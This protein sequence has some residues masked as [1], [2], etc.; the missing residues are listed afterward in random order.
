MILAGTHGTG[1]MP[2]DLD[3]V[4][5]AIAAARTSTEVRRQRAE[6]QREQREQRASARVRR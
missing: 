4:A 1:W 3:A 5:G 6:Q 2:V